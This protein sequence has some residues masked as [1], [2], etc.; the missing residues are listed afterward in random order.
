VALAGGVGWG[1]AGFY[2]YDLLDNLGRP[3]AKEVLAEFQGWHKETQHP[4]QARPRRR[5]PIGSSGSKRIG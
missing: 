3:S 1:R 5:R 2:S 4:C